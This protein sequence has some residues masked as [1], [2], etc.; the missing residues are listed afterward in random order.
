MWWT[1][2]MPCPDPLYVPCPSIPH[3]LCVL[4]VKTHSYALVW[5][6]V[7]KDCPQQRLEVLLP[8]GG[9]SSLQRQ[10]YLTDRAYAVK[11]GQLEEL[12]ILQSSL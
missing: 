6:H 9:L 3:L 4:S 10:L 5:R 7:L 12:F 8:Q 1:L 2:L 11:A